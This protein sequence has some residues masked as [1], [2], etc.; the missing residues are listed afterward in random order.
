MVDLQW[1]PTFCLTPYDIETIAFHQRYMPPDAKQRNSHSLVVDS[2][3]L[4]E[5]GGYPVRFS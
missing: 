3:T 4:S 2:T 5:G 1:R